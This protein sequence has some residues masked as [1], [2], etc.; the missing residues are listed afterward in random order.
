MMRPYSVQIFQ[1]QKTTRGV[2]RV[3][4]PRGFVRIDY[5]LEIDIE[6]ERGPKSRLSEAET[7]KRS[8][9]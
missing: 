8:A 3:E 2:K 4:Q 1:H 7:S 6:S 5:R 9:L